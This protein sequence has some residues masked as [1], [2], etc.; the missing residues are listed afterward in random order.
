MDHAPAFPVRIGLTLL[1]A[2]TALL[3]GPSAATASAGAP[4]P[5]ADDPGRTVSAWLPYWGDTQ[6][7]YRD[8]VDHAAQLHTVSPFWYQADSGTLI[9]SWPGAADKAVVDGLHAAGIKVVPTVTESLDAATMGP[10]LGDAQRRAAHVDALMK[11]VA[12]AS[13]DGLDLDYERMAATGDTAQ[14]ERVRTGYNAM[15]TEL[16]GRLHA[17]KK[18]CVVTVMARTE[19]GGAYDY[20]HLGRTADRMRIMGYDLHWAGGPPGPLSSVG[21]YGDFLRY[22]TGSVPREK[23]EVA[24]PGYGWD[25]T[26]GSTARAQ[27]VT[28]KDAEALRKSKGIAY[29]FDESSGTP[30]FTY[31]EGGARHEVWYQD[32]RGV[33]AH[34]AVLK[35][36]GVRNTGLWA[37]AFED[38][39]FWNAL[40]GQ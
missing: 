6:G 32:A 4:G 8:A 14:R 37:L 25:W 33:T 21:W 9:K 30:H 26:A 15:T 3:T 40:R 35:K 2:A 28:W 27:H 10:L 34:L 31:T 12:S 24:F 11:V 29:Q 39:A 36:Y 13:Y 16:C 20:P 7:A 23:I 18:S 5:R 38:P 22:A 19:A 17:Q 1:L